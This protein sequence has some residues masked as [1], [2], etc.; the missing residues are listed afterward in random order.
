MSRR[1]FIGAYPS[2]VALLGI[3]M[4]WTDGVEACLEKSQKEK[5][6]E[7]DKKRK[8]VNGIMAELT[9]MCLEDMNRLVRM[10]V[11][12][13]VT[14][15]VHQRDL[16]EEIRTLAREHK[17]KDKL[18]FEWARNTRVAWRTDDGNIIISVT[19]VDFVY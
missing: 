1:D 10:K 11:E 6:Q 16:F 15:H 8:D 17:V 19:D 14:I 12:T 3:Q 18:D 4:I 13:L 5:I 9:E 2:Q 7:F